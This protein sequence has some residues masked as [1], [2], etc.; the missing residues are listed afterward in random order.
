VLISTETH[1]SPNVP[2]RDEQI[3]R[4]SR[5]IIVPGIG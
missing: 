3:E 4:Y 5:Q 1:K 2:L